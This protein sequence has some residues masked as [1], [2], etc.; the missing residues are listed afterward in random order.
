MHPKQKSLPSWLLCLNPRE[1]CEMHL[2]GMIDFTMKQKFQS[3]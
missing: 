3:P 2:K 1:G